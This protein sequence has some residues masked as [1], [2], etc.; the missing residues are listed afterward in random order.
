M[1]WCAFHFA[2]GYRKMSEAELVKNIENYVR[3]REKGLPL[4][5]ITKNAEQ[6][7]HAC[8]IPYDQL[9]A[10][11]ERENAV[12][13]KNTDYRRLDINNVLMIPRILEARKGAM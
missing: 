13:G 8:L 4:P 12:T 6:R 2:N 1:R 3:C 9:D 10:L 5:R 11:S 7:T